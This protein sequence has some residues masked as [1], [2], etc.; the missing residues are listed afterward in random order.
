MKYIPLHI[1]LVLFLLLSC[2]D[3]RQG[4]DNSVRRLNISFA[5]PQMRSV[6]ND[7][8]DTQDKV[9]YVW[10]NNTNMLTAIKHN[11]QYVP[12]YA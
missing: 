1:M 12:F 6:W 4:L 5:E 2:T 7:L 11:G 10:E 9:S 8:T 3:E